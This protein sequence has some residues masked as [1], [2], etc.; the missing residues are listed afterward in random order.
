MGT[1]WLDGDDDDDL[2][3]GR[4]QRENGP[5]E[6]RKAYKAKAA[7][8]AELEAQIAELTARTRST[9]VKT[10]LSDL[11]ISD[12]RVVDLIPES[13]SPTVEAIGEWVKKYEGIFS[14]SPSSPPAGE[15][16]DGKT[17]G[18]G[19]EGGANLP[20]EYRAGVEKTGKIGSV[21]S[22]NPAAAQGSHEE[23][24]ASLANKGGTFEDLQ[25][26]FKDYKATP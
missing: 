2:E 26:A 11:G 22:T 24:L 7:R 18:A 8:V 19:K 9:D 16:Q 15:N 12:P 23:F 3:D 25:K 1:N 17:D 6:L 21:G 13:V 5:R 4:Q 20:P 14:L 10:I